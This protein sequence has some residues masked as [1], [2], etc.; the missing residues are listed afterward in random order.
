MF[1]FIKKI[2]INNK[3][4]PYVIFLLLSLAPF[5]WRD[6]LTH[7]KYIG[8]GDFVSPINAGT[9]LY[10][11]FFVYN[12]RLSGGFDSSFLS[13]HIFPFLFLYVI[14]EKLSITPYVT[15]LFLISLI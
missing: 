6:S 9:L 15:T 13:A 14:F 3:V 7:F 11:R 1:S 8:S 5:F 4:I 2:K 12:S 10:E